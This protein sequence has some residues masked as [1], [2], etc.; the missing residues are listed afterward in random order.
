MRNMLAAAAAPAPTKLRFAHLMSYH[1]PIPAASHDDCIA[2]FHVEVRIRPDV[3]PPAQ[4]A[5]CAV[6]VK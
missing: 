1:M 5:R 6:I 2:M 4:A 3:V